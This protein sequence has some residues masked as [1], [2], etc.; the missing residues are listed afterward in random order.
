MERKNLARGLC[1]MRA[2]DSG[3]TY[4]ESTAAAVSNNWLP[5][6]VHIPP[7]MC[8]TAPCSATPNSGLYRG[9]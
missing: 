2:A 6:Q 5:R 1:A 7:I 3:G 9:R 4:S 8:I